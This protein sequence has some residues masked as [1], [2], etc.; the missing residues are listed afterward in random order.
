[1]KMCRR[2]GFHRLSL[3][4]LC[5]SLNGA[6]AQAQLIPPTN[7]VPLTVTAG[8][9]DV[10]GKFFGQPPDPARTRH[11]YI[12]AEPQLWDYAPEGRDPV[13]G[14]PFPPPVVAKR[15]GGKM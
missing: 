15:S 11:Y 4:L 8:M 10:G 3:V 5:L 1:M 14:K 9:G 2:T 13:C 12:A 7:V 6:L